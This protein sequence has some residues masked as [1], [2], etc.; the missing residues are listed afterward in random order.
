[1]KRVGKGI[2]IDL[3]TYLIIVGYAI[4]LFTNVISVMT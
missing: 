4:L 3:K 1:M 2:W